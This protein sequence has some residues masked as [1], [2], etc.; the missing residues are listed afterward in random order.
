MRFKSTM[1]SLGLLALAGTAAAQ[2]ANPVFSYSGFGTIGYAITD[3]DTG[4]YTTGTQLYGATKHGSFDPD[5]KVGLQINGKFSD[6]FS[7]TMQLFAKQDAVGQ[8]GPSIEWAFLKAK[9]GSSFNVRA[10]RM[11]AP[12]FMT[13]D[14]RNVGYTNLSVRTPQDVYAS[15]P[16]RS[17]DG[18]DLLYQGS[19]GD[20]TINAQLWGGKAS[21][22]AA[23]DT[24]VVLNDVIGLSASAEIGA[25]TL[26]VGH[27][28]T[29]LTGEGS[30]LVAFNGLINTMRAVSA[31]PGLSAH[32]DF[33]DALAID[34]KMAT[35]SGVGASF[36]LG[37]WVGSAEITKRKTDSLYVSDI[38]AWYTTLGY[39]V[40]KLTPYVSLSARKVDSVTSFASPVPQLNAAING[41]AGSTT[42]TKLIAD[43]TDNTTAIGVRWEAGKSY[44][45]KAEYANIA[46]PKG[47]NGGLGG[48]PG[49]KFESDTSV[50]V[51]SVAVDFVF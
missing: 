47:S 43:N 30:G 35:F 11:G 23:R 17:F 49:G 29:K 6:V 3:T 33:A 26:R 7:G 45:V 31:T 9:L 20:T 39:R 24:T 13:S 48:V 12:F 51:F 22:L 2:E 5:T 42:V 16:V 28:Q 27:M 4:T 41:I 18:A 36:E 25:V 14:F 50:N 8:Y 46:I 15:V 34:G 19:F 37:Q 1:V 21:A 40:N 32:K 10:G 44:A 38:S